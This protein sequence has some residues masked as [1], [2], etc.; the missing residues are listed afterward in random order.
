MIVTAGLEVATG[1]KYEFWLHAVID[2]TKTAVA[3]LLST[4][5]WN[6]F[7]YNKRGW[8]TWRSEVVWHISHLSLPVI[9]TWF[10]GSVTGGET[11][12]SLCSLYSL[13]INRKIFKSLLLNVFLVRK[14]RCSGWLTAVGNWNCSLFDPTREHHRTT[15]CKLL[16]VKSVWGSTQQTRN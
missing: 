3:P 8:V 10:T 6:M 7:S 2:V 1:V 14:L 4:Q 15:G 5:P 12:P 11:L 9:L 13:H 16:A